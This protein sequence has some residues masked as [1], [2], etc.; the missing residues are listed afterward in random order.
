MNN[1]NVSPEGIMKLLTGVWASGL[2]G[3]GVIHSVFT[4]L[5]SGVDT[6]DQ[7]VD[8]LKISRRGA[9]VLLDGLTGL[10]LIQTREGRY[11]NTPEASEFL[12]EGKPSYMGGL[13]KVEGLAMKPWMHFPEAVKTG[14]PFTDEEFDLNA[15]WE[16]LVPAIM[17]L[18]FPAARFS[19]EKLGIRH[20]GPISILDIGGGSG[21]FATVWLKDNP[22]ARWTQL[23]WPGVNRIARGIV[24]SVGVGDRFRTIDGDFHEVDFGENAYDYVIYS[25]IAHGESPKANREVFRKVQSALMN[26]GC[27]VIND[28]VLKDDRSGS[29]M[30]LVFNANMLIKTEEGECWREKDYKSWLDETGFRDIRVIPTPGPSTLIIA[31]Q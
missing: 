8:R 31:R 11:W 28:F 22:E 17:P 26:N 24:G 30:G 21:V 13:V 3:A 27:F 10:G 1:T 19:S 15:F 23:D 12:V 25:Q 5:E 2:L 20:A 14:L 6:L 4:Q 29:P 16:S 18:G 9:Q 7:I